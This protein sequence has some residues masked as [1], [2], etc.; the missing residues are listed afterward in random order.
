MDWLCA[1]ECS[2]RAFDPT[3]EIKR[4]QLSS[5]LMASI[6]IYIYRL[7]IVFLS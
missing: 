5:T 1:S 2:E 6:Y 3:V 7:N 4:L